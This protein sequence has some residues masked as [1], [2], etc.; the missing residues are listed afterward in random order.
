MKRKPRT[1]SKTPNKVRYTKASFAH[2]VG[3]R[4]VKKSGVALYIYRC[5]RCDGWHL[6]REKAKGTT[7]IETK[8]AQELELMEKAS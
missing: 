5:K 7:K 2:E 6:T 8:A 1:C 4:R 3:A